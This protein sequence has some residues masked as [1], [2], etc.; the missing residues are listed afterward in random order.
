MKNEVFIETGKRYTLEEYV[1]IASQM[2]SLIAAASENVQEINEIFSISDLL[3][4][5]NAISERM[6]GEFDIRSTHSEHYQ[7]VYEP[8]PFEASEFDDEYIFVNKPIEEPEDKES[9]VWMSE[10]ILEAFK[11]Q[12]LN[13]FA[14][15]LYLHLGFTMNNDAAFGVSQHIKFQEIVESCREYAETSNA[16]FQTTLMRALA[17]LEDVGLVKWHAKAHTFQLLHITSYDPTQKV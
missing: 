3:D 14:F 16:R 6:S 17:D 9:S 2:M 1:P 11:D 13:G 7:I 12:Q 5:L 15:I 8:Y 10:K 4:V